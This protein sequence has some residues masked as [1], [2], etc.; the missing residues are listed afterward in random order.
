M[1]TL[2]TGTVDHVRP[3]CDGGGN[4]K[5]NLVTACATCNSLKANSTAMNLGEARLV[6]AERR[7]ERI[8]RMLGDLIDVGVDPP[9]DAL[10]AV[11][12]EGIQLDLMYTLAHYA[13]ASKH[14]VRDIHQMSRC[15]RG[16]ER[17]I[18][19]ASSRAR[20]RSRFRRLLG[21]ILPD[22]ALRLIRVIGGRWC[23]MVFGDIAS[24]DMPIAAAV[25]NHPGQRGPSMTIT[26]LSLLLSC[27]MIITLARGVDASDWT[28]DEIAAS[29]HTLTDSLLL[30]VSTRRGTS[31]SFIEQIEL[32][33]EE[34]FRFRDRVYPLSFRQFALLEQIVLNGGSVDF[35]TL[36]EEIWG[37]DMAPRNRIEKNVSLLK[38]KTKAIACSRSRCERDG[39]GLRSS[40]ILNQ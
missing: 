3:R 28:K 27:T 38:Q 22:R 4:S 5:E 12:E 2:L 32:L 26:R 30:L 13:K 34:R 15:A 6:V 18:A 31:G 21:W 37:D 33:S 11:L 39:S 17:T 8:S 24:P 29:I 16:L 20:R 35:A 7:A 25:N 1:A 36:G 23:Q 9:P 14:L 10:E 19:R 40:G